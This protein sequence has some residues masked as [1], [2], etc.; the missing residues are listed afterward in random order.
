ML[1]RVS[2]QLSFL[3]IDRARV[4]R[5]DNGVH[6]VFRTEARGVE[7]VYLP[8]ASTASTLLGPGT[9]VTQPAAAQILK[10]GG[11]IV[12]SGASGSHFHGSLIHE[13]LTTRWIHL[14]ASQW[15][16]E[17]Q[18]AQ[19]AK[20][21]YVMRFTDQ[22]ITQDKTVDQLRG[23]EGH[24]VKQVYR[25]MSKRHGIPFRRAYNPQN[26]DE[27]D[28]VNQALTTANHI[29]YGAVQ[30]VICALGASP[31]LGFIHTGGQRSFV[32][33]IADLYKLE[34]AVPCAFASAKADDPVQSV[35]RLMRRNWRMLRLTKR[36]VA[37]I[38]HA[39]DPGNPRGE[40]HESETD[41]VHLWSPE[42]GAL[43]AGMNYAHQVDQ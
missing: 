7:R 8:T 5:D 19:T 13:N 32:Y 1:P 36:I 27:S 22:T 38:Q 28:P 2:D 43:P 15:A 33:D 11:I 37:D 40:P 9:S 34:I 30:S 14:Q 10:D 41:V 23:M 12:L 6:A 18:R 39:L 17:A 16:D 31:T 3:Y 42:R 29:L 21:L 35:R 4:E 20:R 24:R 26:F 25:T